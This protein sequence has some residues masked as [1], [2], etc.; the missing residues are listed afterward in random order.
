MP[1]LTPVL[2]EANAD[3]DIDTQDFFTIQ[4]NGKLILEREEWRCF[5]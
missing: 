1:S 2:R 5:Y 4:E 3:F